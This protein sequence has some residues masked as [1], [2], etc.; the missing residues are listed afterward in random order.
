MILELDLIYILSTLSLATA[1]FTNRISLVF[2]VLASGI[3]AFY[4]VQ[5]LPMGT[6]YLVAGLVWVLISVHSLFHYNDKWLTMTLSGTVLG[7]IVVLTSTNYIEFLAGWETMTLFS[8]VGIAIYR[9][10]WKPALTFLAFGELSTALLLAGFTLAYS[11]TGSL[12]FEK[13]STQLPLI[14]TSMGFIVKMGI[15]PFLVVEWL[16]IAHGN[17][18]SDLSAVL[19]ATV[20]MTGIYG[21]LKMESLSPVSTY[22][23]IF[24]LAVGAFSNL[25]GALYSYVSDHVKGLLAFST[26][27]NN[28]AMLALL[29]SLELVS[30]DL[31]GFVTFS[32]FT[33]VI[34]HSLAKTGLFLSTG[35]VEGESLTTANSFRHGLSVLGTVLMAMSLSGLLPTIGGIATWS[36]LESMFMEAITLPHFINIVPVVAGVMIGMGEGFATG[37]LA[38]FVSYTQLTKPIKDKQGLILAVS[39]ILLLVTVGLAYLLSPFKTEVSQLGVGLNSLIS[40]QYQRSF[41]GIDPLY[42]LVSWPI[43]ALIVYLS[44]GKRKIRVV[45]P[46]DNGSAQGFR[47]TSFGMANNVRLMLRAFL[48]TK[49]GSLETSADIFWQAMLVLIRWYLKF[50]RTFSRSFMNGSLRWYMIYMIIAIVVI[51]VITL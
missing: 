9:K 30:G 44:L 3:L 7:I 20:T 26:I 16:P 13:L 11:Q 24:L 12:A 46:W 40:S 23:G 27:E 51:M 15:F 4:G 37:S 18:R 25:F 36:L 41:G 39:G 48:R 38:K 8:F 29:G 14:I 17:A 43:I 2:L 47:Y 6:F 49:T 5:E 45:D 28:G 31:K 10:Y 33:Y 21:I 19:S 50:S 35:Y 22:L 34:A 42:I 1:F 32:L